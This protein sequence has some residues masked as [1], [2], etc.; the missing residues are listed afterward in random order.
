MIRGI[1]LNSGPRTV[2]PSIADILAT[3]LKYGNKYQFLSDGA[4]VL[5]WIKHTADEAITIQHLLMSHF[6]F[7]V[8]RDSM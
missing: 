7:Q 8:R 6:N 3:S 4:K 5:Q 2:C 1:H